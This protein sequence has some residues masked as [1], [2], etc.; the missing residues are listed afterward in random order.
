MLSGFI[1]QSEHLSILEGEKMKN[2][3]Y[4]IYSEPA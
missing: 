3:F 4:V 1:S 2:D